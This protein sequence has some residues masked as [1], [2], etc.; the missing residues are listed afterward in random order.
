MNWKRILV[1]ILFPACPVFG[2]LNLHTPV[3]DHMVLQRNKPLTLKGTAEP[4]IE[5]TVR[6]GNQRF[7]VK[8]AANGSWN[9]NTSPLL[10][11]GV[12]FSIIIYAGKDSVICSDLLAGDL[13]I[14]IGQSN[15]EW[16]LGKD[17]NFIQNRPQET[18][19]FL[20]WYNPYYAGKGIYS[21]LF[22]D[23]VRLQLKYG[24]FYK[25][26]WEIDD[27]A[28]RPRMSAI[29]YY[30]GKRLRSDTHIPIGLI[31][32]SIGG[33]P[34]E[35]F[36]SPEALSQSKSFRAK[37]VG[38]W[39]RNEHLPV[40]VRERGGQN[41][42]SG[43]QPDPATE[44]ELAHPF[45]PSFAYTNGIRLFEGLQIAGIICYQGES[46]AQELMRVNE[47]AALQ[48]LMLDDY[49]KLWNMPKLPYYFVQLSSIDSARYNSR[50]WPEFRFQQ[51]LFSRTVPGTG[52]A[53]ASDH[54]S[55]NDV[56]PRNKKPV[57]E[58]LALLAL[59]NFY[60]H[61]VQALGPIPRKAEYRKGKVVVF[62][63]KETAPLANPGKDPVIGFSIDGKQVIAKI[64]NPYRIDIS[65][66]TR[67]DTVYY[68]W[69]PFTT[70]NLNNTAGLPCSTFRMAIH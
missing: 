54:G 65:C 5:V 60:H 66:R 10:A 24:P 30:F 56:H 44:M 68:G 23:S 58:R 69:E 48:K 41:L 19:S 57:G 70:A 38:S 51:Y 14:C 27:S 40:W 16:P 21:S 53:V 11:T 28:S 20:R 63:S 29:A 15:M 42:I 3:E 67:P 52:M 31:Q 1:L 12:P 13:W 36:I 9:L 18:D 6:M 35:T 43:K 25:G 26:A 55:F 37:T 46:N 45:K 62:F 33:A 34:L 61:P 47:Y 17:E 22:P 2:Q 8:A 39:L 4:G 64:T 7:V 50:Y 59:R 49:R 32:L